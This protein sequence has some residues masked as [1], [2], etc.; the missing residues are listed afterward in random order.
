M[1]YERRVDKYLLR[2][3]GRE[4]EI[5]ELTL[6]PYDEVARP[7]KFVFR[8]MVELNWT[9]SRFFRNLRAFVDPDSSSAAKKEAERRLLSEA[10]PLSNDAPRILLDMT[11]AYRT[12]KVTGIQRVVREVARHAAETGQG[13]PVIIENGKLIPYYR[14]ASLPE[15]VEIQDGDVFVMLD[16]TW[17]NLAEYRPIMREISNRGGANVVCLYDLLPLMF[18]QAFPPSLVPLFERWFEEALTKSDAV[19]AISQSAAQDLLDYIEAMHS[20]LKPNFRVGWWRLG[21]DFSNSTKEEVSEKARSLGQGP[22]YFLSVGTIEPRK[23]YPIALDAFERL[24]RDGRNVRYAI[25]GRRGWSARHMVSRILEHREYGSR[26]FWFDDAGDADL[27][28]LYKHARAVLAPSFAEGFGLPI[29]EAARHGLPTIAS[30]IPVFREV[31]GDAI[32]YFDCLDS[33]SLADKIVEF[34]G[35]PKSPPDLPQT[36]WRE[37]TEMLLTLIRSKAYQIS[38]KKRTSSAPA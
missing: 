32:A 31:G 8:R 38:L 11:D 9:L 17:N 15:M 6:G 10:A 26:L 21:A 28:F 20:A 29:V 30:D 34:L 14:A 37:S 12:G 2:E 19:V 25:V 3:L 13:L 4:S 23:S 35:T 5:R 27:E 16:A 33:R 1:E 22:S 7:M 36:S 24:W 18:P